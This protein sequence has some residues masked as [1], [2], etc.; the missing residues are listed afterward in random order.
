M[1]FYLYCVIGDEVARESLLFGVEN[2]GIAGSPVS[3]FCL[4]DFNLLVS[5]FAGSSVPVTRDNVLKHAAVISSV[6][7]ETTPLPFRFGTLA[8]ETELKSFLTA[9]AEALRAKQALV[10]GCVE[11]SIKII[12]DRKW[13]EELSSSDDRLKPGTAFL[14]E[15]RRSILGSEAR[16]DATKRIS[17][18]LNE[19]LADSVKETRIST[20][21]T[22][23]LILAAAHLVER[24]ALDEYRARLKA[25]REERPELHFLVSGPWAPYSFVNIDL[26]FKSQ[27]GVS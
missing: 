18:W 8:T 10:H 11:M 17:G 23:K 4:D 3:F 13:T 2:T 20:N 24:G 7:A 25:A 5:D 22:D 27:F 12:W 26:E 21:T 15:K 14:A 16:A 9:R 19:Q 1:K 6:L